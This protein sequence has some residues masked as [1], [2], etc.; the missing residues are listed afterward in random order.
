MKFLLL[1]VLLLPAVFGP[2]TV[3][4]GLVTLD[5]GLMLLGAV[6]MALSWGPM[7]LVMR[8]DEVI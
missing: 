8:H 5:L 3:V 4:L 6:V 1:L 2:I 7:F